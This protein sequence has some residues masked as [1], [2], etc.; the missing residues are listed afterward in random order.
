MPPRV[1]P[2]RVLCG[3]CL[4]LIPTLGQSLVQLPWR[5]QMA[6]LRLVFGVLLLCSIAQAQQYGTFAVGSKESQD[7]ERGLLAAGYVRVP[8]ANGGWHWG[9]PGTVSSS[10]RTLSGYWG[11]PDI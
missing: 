1:T 7:N 3:N 6:S 4:D 5:K 8:G 11:K 2:C 9:K 10:A